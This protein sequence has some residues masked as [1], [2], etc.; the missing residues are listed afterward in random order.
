MTTEYKGSTF[1]PYS[2]LYNK[3]VFTKLRELFL[4]SNVEADN[5]RFLMYLLSTTTNS[6]PKE[7]LF[8]QLIGHGSNGKSMLISLHKNAVKD[9]MKLVPMDIIE[10]KVKIDRETILNT[11]TCTTMLCE[12][13]RPVRGSS[14]IV[15][16]KNL[17]DGTILYNNNTNKQTIIF[18]PKCHYFMDSNYMHRITNT[19]QNNDLLKYVKYIHFRVTFVNTNMYNNKFV[20]YTND[21]NLYNQNPVG[22]KPMLEYKIVD[23]NMFTTWVYD[24]AVISSYL[25]ILNVFYEILEKK[26]VGSLLLALD[27]L[28][29]QNTK[30]P[31]NEET[32][33]DSWN[34]FIKDWQQYC[35]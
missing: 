28:T 12:D 14:D 21:L 31:N 16:I 27:T 10:Q 4:D 9:L 15:K 26:Y 2:N 3:E 19:R 13:L 34:Q 33:D 1:D 25:E 30:H 7:R 6:F 24:P 32:I 29:E 23:R 5:F 20:N 35:L 11:Q 17:I 8:C 18:H 22:D